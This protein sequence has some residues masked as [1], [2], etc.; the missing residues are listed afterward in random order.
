MGAARTLYT[1]TGQE[2]MMD[3]CNVNPVTPSAK[4]LPSLSV[5]HVAFF[6]RHMPSRPLCVSRTTAS[7]RILTEPAMKTTLYGATMLFRMLTG[8]LPPTEMIIEM[9]AH[10]SYPSLRHLVCA[11]CLAAR[12]PTLICPSSRTWRRCRGDGV[13]VLESLAHYA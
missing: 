7:A 12:A 1:I 6:L 11:V 13:A 4:V 10:A 8:A 5:A 9:T 3:P 2:V